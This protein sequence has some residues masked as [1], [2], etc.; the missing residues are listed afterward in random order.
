MATFIKADGTTT[1]VTP[2]IA[3]FTLR[4]AQNLVGGDVQALTIYDETDRY[5][6]NILMHEEGK[7]IGLPYNQTATGKARM[8]GTLW[9]TD[10]IAGNAVFVTPEEMMD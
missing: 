8:L 2:K 6:G 9:A 10:W 4:E 1:E 3:R 5:I 7:V